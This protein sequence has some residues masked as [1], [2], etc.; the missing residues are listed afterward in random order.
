VPEELSFLELVRRVRAGDD[1]ASTEL[2]RRYEPA[3]RTAVRGRLTDPSL[4]RL[5]DSVDICQ[6]VLANFFVRAT[7][8]E[9][10]LEC[11]D[12]LIRLLATLARHRVTDHALRQG[13][14]RRDHRRTESTGMNAANLADPG[15]SPSELVCSKELLHAFQSR[16]SDQERYLADQRS[17]GHPWAKIALELGG[18]PDALRIK[19]E[20]AVTRVT[21]ELRLND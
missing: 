8:G 17:L 9:F 5:V 6:S 10:E 3:I 14:Q 18:N 1:A 7:T 20:R 11:P 4:R 13:A 16:L 2:V 21:R 12:Q 19:L 15:P